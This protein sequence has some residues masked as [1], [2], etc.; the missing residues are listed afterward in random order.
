MKPFALAF[1]LVVL[2][3]AGPA[4]ASDATAE[5][6]PAPVG[7]SLIPSASVRVDRNLDPCG[8]CCKRGP[9]A[10]AQEHVPRHR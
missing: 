9:G 7:T 2:G 4:R 3:Y 5:R 6:S 1:A 10:M 8:A